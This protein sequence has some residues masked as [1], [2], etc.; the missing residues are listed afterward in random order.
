MPKRLN[1]SAGTGKKIIKNIKDFNY[2]YKDVEKV[3]GKDFYPFPWTFGDQSGTAVISLTDDG[4]IDQSSTLNCDTNRHD[5]RRP[6]GAYN[7]DTL[8][9]VFRMMLDSQNISHK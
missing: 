1:G 7:D 2:H 9:D 6:L 5:F 4:F 8:Y 3:S